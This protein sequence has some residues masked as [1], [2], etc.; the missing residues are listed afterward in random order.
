MVRFFRR[1]S[2]RHR[3][4]AVLLVTPPPLHEQAW[5]AFLQ[6]GMWGGL[7]R[8]P[9]AL[10]GLLAEQPPTTTNPFSRPGAAPR[11]TGCTR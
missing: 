11:G 9:T 2:H 1:L 6:V 8:T 7:W 10:A 4:V 3:E 5:E